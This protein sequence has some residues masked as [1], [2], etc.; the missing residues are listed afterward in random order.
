MTSV[1]C[2]TV[3]STADSWWLC[4]PT[5]YYVLKGGGALSLACCSRRVCYFVYFFCEGLG[6][7]GWR[8]ASRRARLLTVSID[9]CCV[10]NIAEDLTAH[11]AAPGSQRQPEKL[12]S[13]RRQRASSIWPHCFALNQIPS[14]SR[15]LISGHI[16]RVAGNLTWFLA[17]FA[18]CGN[19]EMPRLALLKNASLQATEGNTFSLVES[20]S[21][22]N[23]A[24]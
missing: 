14:R 18:R 22:I 16:S 5:S 3:E 17:Y 24:P 21:K 1:T 9:V 12:C 13:R 20:I 11:T 15:C 10:I 23:T 7:G 6:G 8:T 4:W 2:F 19:P